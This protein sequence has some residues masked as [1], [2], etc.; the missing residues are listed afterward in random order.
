MASPGPDIQTPSFPAL[1][2]RFS[3]EREFWR[4]FRRRYIG[5]VSLLFLLFVLFAAIFQDFTARGI[6]PI[7]I[8]PT[9]PL[10]GFTWEHWMGTDTLGRDTWARLVVGARTAMLV[11]LI[12][13]FIGAG[14]G[15]PIGLLAGW[16]GG[17]RDELLMRLMDAI[18]AFPALLLALIII[19]GLGVGLTNVMIAI[20]VGFIPSFA[21][22]VRG[23][24]LSVKEQDYVTAAQS[25]GGGD[26]RIASRH[27]LPNTLAPVIVQGSLLF[28]V[29]IIIE[30]A[31]SFLGLGTQPPDPSW[32]IMLAA[33]QRLIRTEP[34]LALVPGVTISLTVLAF[35]LVG[36]VLRD[37][38]DPRLRGAD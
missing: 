20:G 27:I 4:R 1:N 34:M 13:V 29:A 17:R 25:I 23:S 7:A 22:L 35:N 37:L 6:D 21:R 2:R 36:D 15:L 32:G 30:A 10:A 11:G 19:A 26:I 33:A 8:D 14:L 18:F 5:L 12:S 38:L 3:R 31:L 28:G 9:A 16:W 24:T